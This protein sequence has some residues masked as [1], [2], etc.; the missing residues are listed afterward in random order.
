VLFVERRH[1][2]VEDNASV[3]TKPVL[4]TDESIRAGL[5]SEKKPFKLLKRLRT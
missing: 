5:E 1:R 3:H 4:E 2:Y